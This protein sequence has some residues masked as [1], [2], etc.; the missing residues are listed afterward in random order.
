MSS[1]PEDGKSRHKN[2]PSSIK[3]D[4]C[5]VIQEF[6]QSLQWKQ[7]WLQAITATF[8]TA[9]REYTPQSQAILR[10]DSCNMAPS[11]DSNGKPSSKT[12]YHA[13][14]YCKTDDRGSKKKGTGS[15]HSTF[16]PERQKRP[17]TAAGAYNWQDGDIKDRMDNY[18]VRLEKYKSRWEHEIS[19]SI[20]GKD[21]FG[22]GYTCC[23]N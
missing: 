8:T 7:Y 11:E 15:K 14:L 13:C 20:S 17:V 16:C 12:A 19:S 1:S 5:F 9:N 23:P 18:L 6:P 22:N 10:P 21:S 4:S 2:G 3:N